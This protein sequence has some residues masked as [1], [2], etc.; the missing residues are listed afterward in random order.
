[1]LD[2]C[3]YVRVLMKKQW[4][5]FFAITIVNFLLTLNCL[6]HSVTV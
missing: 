1:M 2:L 4:Y 5:V 3:F 6:C